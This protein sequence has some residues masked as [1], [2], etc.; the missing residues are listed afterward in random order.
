METPVR[1]QGINS[2]FIVLI[3]QIDAAATGSRINGV[4]ANIFLRSI[5]AADREHAEP[6]G[7]KRG[8]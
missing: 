7:I 1:L 2:L 4:R 8:R 3:A 5:Q 6:A